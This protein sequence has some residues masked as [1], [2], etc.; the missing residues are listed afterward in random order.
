MQHLPIETTHRV[1]EILPLIMPVKGD[2]SFERPTWGLGELN[3]TPAKHPDGGVC[4]DCGKDLPD[5]WQNGDQKAEDGR[6]LFRGWRPVTCC[7]ECYAKRRSTTC[8]A[9]EAAWLK[10]CPIEFRAPWSPEKADDAARVSAMKFEASQRKGMVI[11]GSSGAGKTRI[12]WLVAKKVAESG[13]TWLWVDSLDYVDTVPK[14]ASF[15]DVLFLDDF[16][17]EPLGQIAE[18]RLLRLIKT[19]TEQHRPMVITTQHQGDTLS[20]RFRES[21]TAQAVVRRLREFCDSVYVKAR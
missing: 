12:A 19:R 11:H 15:V 14:E 4:R 18:T 9:G 17:N 16:G 8:S 2:G 13:R 20:K 6:W 1:S 3:P 7:E 5:L 21:A 10:A